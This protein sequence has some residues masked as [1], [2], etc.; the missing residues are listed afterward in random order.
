M[1]DIIL[2]LSDLATST[3]NFLPNLISAIIL[4]VIGLVV[5]KIIGRI[6]KEILVRVKLDYYVTE[7]HKPV[8]SLT[9]IFALI[10]RWWIYLA[11]IAAA[12][13]ENVLG[14]PVLAAWVSEIMSFI[15]NIV[16]AVIIVVAGYIIAEYVD[17]QMKKMGRLYADVVS[18]ILFFFIMYVAIAL[19]LPI[20]GIPSGL[21][22]NI[23]LVIIGSLGLGMA[24]AIGL[25]LKDTIAEISKKYVKK[26][27]I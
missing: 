6:V 18:K 24:I 23:L 16:G 11:F 4:L 22:N 9:D 8:I 15:P 20:L 27:K 10:V 13:S 1:S 19:A 17:A 25:G 7:T 2:V 3:A 26:L 12:L 5:G 21:V 14:I